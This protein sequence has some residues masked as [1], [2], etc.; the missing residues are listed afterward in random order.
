MLVGEGGG[1]GGECY[2]IVSGLSQIILKYDGIV[3]TWDLALQLLSFALRC[4][5]LALHCICL[6]L[7]R[8]ATLEGKVLHTFTHKPKV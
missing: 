6:A 3:L 4:I 2:S 7:L 1:D 5:A 8:H